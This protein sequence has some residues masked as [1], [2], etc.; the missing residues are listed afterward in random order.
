MGLFEVLITNM[1]LLICGANKINLRRA[2]API[3]TQRTGGG[4]RFYAPLV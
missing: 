4:G 1:M 3:V 2:G